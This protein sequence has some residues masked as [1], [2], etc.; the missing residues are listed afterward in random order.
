MSFSYRKS[1]DVLKRQSSPSQPVRLFRLLLSIYFVLFPAAVVGHSSGEIA[2]AYACNAIIATEAITIAYYRGQSLK[3]LALGGG[4][5]TV[6]LS[7]SETSNYLVNDVT[8]VCEN[9]PSSTTIS[10]H[11]VK[12]CLVIERLKKSAALFL[13]VD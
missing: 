11:E 13:S 6:G 4:M 7:R 2:A 12:V 9:S 3:L 10:G 8:I 5:A 1:Q